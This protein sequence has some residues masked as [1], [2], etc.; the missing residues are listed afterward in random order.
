MSE[1]LPERLKLILKTF[2]LFED[3]VQIFQNFGFLSL[4]LNDEF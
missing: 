1:A 3:F 4:Y 2:I